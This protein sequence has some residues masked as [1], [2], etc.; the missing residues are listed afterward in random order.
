MCFATVKF[1]DILPKLRRNLFY[2][3]RKIS[4]KNS[5]KRL[6]EISIDNFAGKIT[7]LKESIRSHKLESKKKLN[8]IKLEAPCSI[9]HNKVITLSY[10][11]MEIGMRVS[12]TFPP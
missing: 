10:M 2:S 4:L 8:F 12:Q 7:T 3:S 1:S 9:K 11:H 6:W 5:K